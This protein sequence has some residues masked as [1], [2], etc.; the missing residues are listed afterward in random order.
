MAGAPAVV[1]DYDP[2]TR[3]FAEQT[4]QGRWAVS[5]DE[6]EGSTA[7]GEPAGMSPAAGVEGLVWA[8][9]DTM[10]ALASRRAALA[11][12]VMPLRADAGRTAGLAV[13]LAGSGGALALPLPYGVKT[14]HALDL[15]RR[16]APE[17]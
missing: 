14:G 15:R 10:A 4:G 3:A 11:R 17:V 13:Q 5:V 8:I 7:A 9:T 12:A 2:K 6:L 1:L 16:R